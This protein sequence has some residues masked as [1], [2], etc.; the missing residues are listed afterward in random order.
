LDRYQDDYY[1]SFDDIVSGNSN[2]NSVGP[3]TSLSSNAY[4]VFSDDLFDGK[5]YSLKFSI[6]EYKDY[7]GEG[8]KDIKKEVYINLQTISKGYYLYLR[9][10]DASDNSNDFFSEPIQ[11][12]NNVEGG[13]GILGSY[14]SSVKK[15][16]L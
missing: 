3:P 16:D 7:Y 6:N 12:F 1:F 11:I 13:I 10:R 2:D 4:N 5:Q 14:T 8:Q 9:T 15:I